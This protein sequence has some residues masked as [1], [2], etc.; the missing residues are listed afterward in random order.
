MNFLP[1]IY[2]FSILFTRTIFS[3]IIIFDWWLQFIFQLT[4][5]ASLTPFIFEHTQLTFF[6]FSRLHPTIDFEV[7]LLEIL[8]NHISFIILLSYQPQSFNIYFLAK[9]IVFWWLTWLSYS[10]FQANSRDW[11]YFANCFLIFTLKPL[12]AH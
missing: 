10:W 5:C 3:K 4:V 12:I 11:Y 9:F 1:A 2:L 7:P 6:L 8:F